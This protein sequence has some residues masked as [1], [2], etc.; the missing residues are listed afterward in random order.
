VGIVPGATA[1]RRSSPFG[2]KGIF[3]LDIL[4]KDVK[5]K[6]ATRHYLAGIFL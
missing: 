6:I 2:L 4:A 1:K 3:W 5:I